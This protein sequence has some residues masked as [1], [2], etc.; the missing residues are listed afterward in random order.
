MALRGC[1]ACTRM[2]HAG[3]AKAPPKLVSSAESTAQ[4]EVSKRRST[5]RSV[6]QAKN[7]EKE[8]FRASVSRNHKKEQVLQRFRR[9]TEQGEV[10]LRKNLAALVKP[11][12]ASDDVGSLSACLK[13]L[14]IDDLDLAVLDE[15]GLEAAEVL[16]KPVCWLGEIGVKRSTIEWLEVVRA[17]PEYFTYRDPEETFE[18]YLN[19]LVGELGEGHSKEDVRPLARRYWRLLSTIERSVFEKP[20]RPQI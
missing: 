7:L 6:L 8:Q 2:L 17:Y 5:T 16:E 15:H 13:Q 18:R 20:I 14:G 9:G 4:Y 11:P 10:V 12:R 1:I 19:H 3:K